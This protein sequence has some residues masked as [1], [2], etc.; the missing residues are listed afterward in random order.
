MV[1]FTMV[2]DSPLTCCCIELLWSRRNCDSVVT[3]DAGCI[4]C[5]VCSMYVA[6]LKSA[7]TAEPGEHA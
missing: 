1:H 6:G 7:P 2:E 4:H 3:D 5:D